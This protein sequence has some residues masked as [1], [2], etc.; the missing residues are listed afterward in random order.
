MPGE[1]EDSLEALCG[2]SMA[3]LHQSNRSHSAHVLPKQAA[4]AGGS[5]AGLGGG[6]GKSSYRVCPKSPKCPGY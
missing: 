6:C 4:E 3:V 2:Q 1:Y 5:E